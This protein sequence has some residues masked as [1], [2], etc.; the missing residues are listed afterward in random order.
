MSDSLVPYDGESCLM[1]TK[2]SKCYLAV[3]FGTF[4]DKK[5][6]VFKMHFLN[7]FV[8]KH[9]WAVLSQLCFISVL[10]LL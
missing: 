5:D 10:Y 4:S 2:F 6:G 3:G 7:L 8:V 1:T 9:H